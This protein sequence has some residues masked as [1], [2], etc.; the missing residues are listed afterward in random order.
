M[1][2]HRPRKHFGQN[3][4][5]DR[6]IVDKILRA[7]APRA[8]DHVVE[9]G[10]G[11]GALTRPLLQTVA[12]LDALEID[13][14]LAA[15]LT[16]DL[17]D[18]KLTVHVGDALKF[19]FAAIATGPASLRLVG[20]LPYNISTPLLFH[21]L[22]HSELFL[23][24]HVMLQK[25]V[26]ERMSA[27]PGSKTYGRLTVSLAARCRVESLFV[28][29]P[30]SFTP[31]PRVDSAVARL[32]PDPQRRSRITDE[33]AFDHIVSQAFNQR[34]KRLTN[35]LRNTL[36]AGQIEELDIDPGLRAEM[37]DVDAFIRLGNQFAQSR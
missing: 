1:N 4:L 11:H 7:I 23:D 18:A 17:D 24:A 36:T 32:T 27:A 30:G 21:F 31:S 12:K 20:N 8:T 16:H 9:I 3:F 25:E 34:R 15:A 19:D 14:D 2:A 6:N 26:V 13:R 28:V 5:H 22:D 35:A 33:N 37:L 10:P 29:R